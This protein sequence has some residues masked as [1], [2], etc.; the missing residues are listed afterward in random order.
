MSKKD[1]LTSFLIVI[2]Y[3]QIYVFILQQSWNH[4]FASASDKIASI[5]TDSCLVG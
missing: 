4:D 5:E 2:D 3:F 1:Q